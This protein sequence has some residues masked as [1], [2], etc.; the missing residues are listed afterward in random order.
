MDSMEALDIYQ[1]SEETMS[2][3]RGCGV[4]EMR[5]W[6]GEVNMTERVAWE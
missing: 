5:E 6:V 1:V 4:S 2:E 3:E